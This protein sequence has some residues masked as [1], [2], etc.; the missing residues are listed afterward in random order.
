MERLTEVRR[1]LE[2]MGRIEPLLS[3][4]SEAC[5]G[6]IYRIEDIVERL[7]AYLKSVETN[8][9][10]LEAVEGA[11]GPPQSAEAQ[12]RRLSGNHFRKA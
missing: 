2:K 12:V 9:G 11:A 1:S 10:R 4:Q 7:R 8:E 6:V 3:P 5:A